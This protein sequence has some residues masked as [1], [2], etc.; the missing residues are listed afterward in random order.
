MTVINILCRLPEAAAAAAHGTA[1]SVLTATS[2]IPMG[3]EGWTNLRW[4]LE[5]E[6]DGLHLC[7]VVCL[8]NPAVQ[9]IQ[10]LP[11]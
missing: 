2:V 10:I 6:A 7:N 4:P 1:H 3:W 11:A 8:A 5:I 9:S